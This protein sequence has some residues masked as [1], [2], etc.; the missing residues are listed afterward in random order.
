MSPQLFG[1]SDGLF[2]LLV[3]PTFCSDCP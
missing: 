1:V 2:L 3:I